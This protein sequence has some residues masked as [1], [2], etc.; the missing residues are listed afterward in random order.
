MN[1]VIIVYWRP[2]SGRP[3]TSSD[4]EETAVKFEWIFRFV[5]ERYSTSRLKQ[6]GIW[7]GGRSPDVSNLI[8]GRRYKVRKFYFIYLQ[9]VQ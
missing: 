3:D 1:S 4:F 8:H 7:V 5:N 6:Y 2:G 9:N